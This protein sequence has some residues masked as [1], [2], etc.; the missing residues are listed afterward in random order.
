M[1]SRRLR[2]RWEKEGEND[3]AFVH[4]AWAQLLFN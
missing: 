2:V 3:L 1:R 4:R